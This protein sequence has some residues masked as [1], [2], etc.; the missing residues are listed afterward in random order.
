MRCRCSS[1]ISALERCR[2]RR[3]PAPGESKS[4]RMKLLG[5]SGGGSLRISCS[6]PSSQA[7]SRMKASRSSVGSV[8]RNNSTRGGSPLTLMAGNTAGLSLP[9]CFSAGRLL[10]CAAQGSMGKDL[11]R[12][13]RCG[14]SPTVSMR[15][16]P[17]FLAPPKPLLRP[18][19][20]SSRPAAS[21][22]KGRSSGLRRSSRSKRIEIIF[23]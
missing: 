4:R 7:G 19:S 12:R 15:G 17:M 20:C 18:W 6:V 1:K 3:Q 13:R 5:G 10:A 22:L 14:V 2:P 8:V 16:P 9:H 11:G 21:F 23:L